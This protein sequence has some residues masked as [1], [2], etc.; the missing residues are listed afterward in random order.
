MHTIERADVE[1]RSVGSGRG[2]LR[3]RIVR[4][5]HVR[6][7]T[8]TET[9]LRIRRRAKRRIFVCR[10]NRRVTSAA[11]RMRAAGNNNRQCF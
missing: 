2:D 3:T 1:Q 11:P 6:E 4:T 5:P 9:A 10:D 8:A 7:V